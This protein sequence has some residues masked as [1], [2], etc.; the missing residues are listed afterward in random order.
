MV[1]RNIENC[2]SIDK[3]DGESLDEDN[4]FEDKFYKIKVKIFTKPIISWHIYS[5]NRFI[6]L[7]R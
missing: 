2:L 7:Y 1:S 4:L 6:I 3:S 5:T